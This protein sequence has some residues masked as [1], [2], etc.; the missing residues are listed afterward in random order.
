MV[1]PTTFNDSSTHVL[2]FSP[3]RPTRIFTSCNFG[4]HQPWMEH[5]LQP[6]KNVALK[7]NVAIMNSVGCSENYRHR[8]KYFSAP[9][10]HSL[11]VPASSNFDFTLLVGCTFTIE[12]MV[13][14]PLCTAVLAI[15]TTPNQITTCCCI[16]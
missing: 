4:S 5:V 7:S 8:S 11:M 15:S 13:A 2:F 3:L 1:I 10:G 14:Y 12:M 6:K 16:P 9:I